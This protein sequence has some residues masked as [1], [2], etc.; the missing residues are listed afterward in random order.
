MKLCHRFGLGSPALEGKVEE[1]CV[2]K[3][4]AD[5]IL[6]REKI[7][8]DFKTWK[9]SSCFETGTFLDS[10]ITFYFSEDFLFHSS[11]GVL[12]LL[13]RLFCFLFLLSFLAHSAS[14]ET[15]LTEDSTGAPSSSDGASAGSVILSHWR[16]TAKDGFDLTGLGIIAGGI[17]GVMIAQPH[18]YENRAAWSQYQKMSPDTAKI[19][20]YLGTGLWGISVTIAQYFLDRERAYAHA[21]SLLL[22][23]ETT[24]VLKWMNQRNRPNSDD[25]QSMPSGHTSTAFTTATHLAVNYGWAVGIPA[26]ALATFVAT[27]RWTDDAHWLSDTVAGAAIGIFWGRASAFHHKV[28]VLPV[29]DRGVYG[30]QISASY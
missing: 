18:D 9:R 27:T 3:F 30:V 17:A 28:Q 29:V 10:L 5:L 25:R 22:A 13:K 1:V 2:H 11:Q 4:Y 7:R 16:Q 8:D 26:Y 21:E 6:R 24:I 14:A 12:I 23:F 19:G 15:A 20:N